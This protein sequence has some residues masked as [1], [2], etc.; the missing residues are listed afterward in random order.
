[1]KTNI[2]SVQDEENMKPYI[3]SLF[4]STSPA[5]NVAHTCYLPSMPC[6]QQ[7]LANIHRDTNKEN[8]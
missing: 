5:R 8:V 6:N 3:L 1:M 7:M 4:P 2:I